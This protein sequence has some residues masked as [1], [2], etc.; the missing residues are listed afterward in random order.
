MLQCHPH[1]GDFSDKSKPFHCSYFMGLQ[2]KNGV[3]VNEG[4]T[5][6]MRATVKEFKQAVNVY[7]LWKP[8]M[9]IRVC[10]LKKK[11]IPN[12]VFPSGVRP[13]RPSKLTWDMR[14]TLELKASGHSQPEKSAVL[15]GVDQARKRKQPDDI[16]DNNIR[17]VK[18]VAPSCGDVL[19]TSSPISTVS[20]C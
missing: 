4:G 5:F 11:S 9:E 12:F 2:K 1:P 6:D 3:S 17:N 8:G 16:I 19:D 14:R 13:P 7:D 10:H 15:D 18:S 20:S